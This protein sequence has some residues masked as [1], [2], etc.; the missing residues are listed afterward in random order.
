MIADFYKTGAG[1]LSFQ[2]ALPDP[3]YMGDDAVI[4]FQ[5]SRSVHSSNAAVV[6]KISI[7]WKEVVTFR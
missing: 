6:D 5:A 7:V 1:L 2:A 4:D 3:Y